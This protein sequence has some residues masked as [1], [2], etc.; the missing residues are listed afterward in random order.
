MPTGLKI[1]LYERNQLLNKG[2]NIM[3]ECIKCF[4]TVCNFETILGE[5]VCE[6]CI[7]SE[8]CYLNEDQTLERFGN[9]VNNSNYKEFYSNDE[10]ALNTD[11]CNFTDSL[12]KDGIIS[13]ELDN[14]LCL[15]D[16]FLNSHYCN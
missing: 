3:K 12:C 15:P 7:E 10:V 16:N 2:G 13:K 14:S 4:D 1:E 5:F 8:L 9:M 11:F 6:E